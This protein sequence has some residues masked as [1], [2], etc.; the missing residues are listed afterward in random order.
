MRPLAVRYKRPDTCPDTPSSLGPC[1]YGETAM[2]ESASLVPANTEEAAHDLQ[3]R[4]A[5]FARAVFVVTAVIG[6]ASL[7]TQ[8][9]TQGRI[10]G[11]HA[12]PHELVH[13][14]ALVLASATWLR[15]RRKPMSVRTLEILDACLTVLICVLYALLGFTAA[16]SLGVGFTVL[17][18]MTYTL[19]GRSILVPS[20]F[21]RTL[22]ISIF[23]ATPAIAYFVTAGAPPGSAENPFIFILFATMWCVFAVF[24]AAANSRQLY[25][26]RAKI[27]EIGKLGQYTLEEKLGE[28]GMGV[29][30]RATHAMLRRPAAIKLL[31][32][33]RASEKDQVRFERE[34]QLTSRL[35]HPNTISIFDYGRTA[36]GVF[37]YV[38][39]Y[40]DG[41]DLDR[42]V[43]TVGPIEPPRAIHILAQVAGALAEA[44]A[45]GLIH[46]DIKPANIVL[47]ERADEPD[48]VKVVDFGLVRSLESGHNE[49]VAAN[50]VTGTPMYLSPEA[51]SAPET[52][53]G[54]ADIY[55]LGAVAYFLVTGEHVFEGGTILELCSRHLVT[56]PI[57]PSARLGRPLPTDLEALILKS[58]AKERD[59]RPASAVALRTALL[60]CADATKYDPRAASSWWAAHRAAAPG[61]A[62]RGDISASAPTMAV[63]LRGRRTADERP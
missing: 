30:H 46:R 12:A 55:A 29:V 24:T 52:I 13:V 15:C 1:Y 37:Y 57:A 18:A 59:D 19:V 61:T 31:L 40:L 56:P 4:L 44:H 32:K 49:S 38:M 60:G 10:H 14:C 25:G 5:R 33:D 54:R 50:V 9:V 63:D 11:G 35:R 62:H 8:L 42:L 58:L 47:T 16:V 22:W 26:L 28:G 17:L 7:A 39:E 45:L 20:A 41:M 27:R 3:D 36:D 43:K 6:F 51:I 53:D 23:G 34:V 21:S 48:V 2:S